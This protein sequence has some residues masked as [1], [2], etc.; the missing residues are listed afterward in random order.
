MA[1][2]NTRYMQEVEKAISLVRAAIGDLKP[3]MFDRGF[4]VDGFLHNSAKFPDQYAYY[5]SGKVFFKRVIA[6]IEKAL[7]FLDD[8][9][10]PILT[11]CDLQSQRAFDEV[12]LRQRKLFETMLVTMMLSRDAIYAPIGVGSFAA[13]R[14]GLYYLHYHLSQEH[15]YL[16]YR[17]NFCSL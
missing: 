16:N 7:S 3:L 12:S 4:E 5:A 6:E 10:E 8:L 13:P 14:P 17:N 15:S 9:S 11:G 2:D 1:I